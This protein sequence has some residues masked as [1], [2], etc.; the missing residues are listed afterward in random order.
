MLA[1]FENIFAP[2]RH[3]ILLVLALWAGLSL[4]ERRADRHGISR[5]HL[6]NL[7]FYC[8]AAYILG[9]R[10][11]FVLEN[12]SSFLRSPLDII[13]IS[14]N[15]FDPIAAA[16]SALLAGAI[17]EYRQ[18][19]QARKLLDALTIIFAV[20]AIGLG[21]SHLAAETAYGS[22]TVMPWGIEM[23][24]A[25]RHPSQ[26]YEI[27]AS[28]L[29]FGMVWFQRPGARPGTLFLT[30]IALSS[31]S[32]LFLEAFRGDSHFVFGGIRSAQLIALCALV[33]SFAIY[34]FIQKKVIE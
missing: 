15:I 7:V 33:L 18:K 34:E 26:V 25:T 31:G 32:R 30:F 27:I 2:P 4:A 22:P 16:I 10:T 5:E 20:L 23:R 9:G 19:L 6:S 17:Y 24:N 12:L 1:L 8:L 21:L 11:A 28:L 3:L 14:P 29:T 13:S